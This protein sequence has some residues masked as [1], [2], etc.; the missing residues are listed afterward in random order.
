M[1]FKVKSKKINV[2]IDGE[3]LYIVEPSVK[4]L[5]DTGLSTAGDDE[6]IDAIA[7]LLY[8]VTY[9]ENGEKAFESVDDVLALPARVLAEFDEVIVQLLGDDEKK[10]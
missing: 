6:K 1:A 5:R 2:E 7:R 3:R 10:V 4:V 8:E 9:M